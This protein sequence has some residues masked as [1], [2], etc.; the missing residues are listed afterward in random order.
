MADGV[1]TGWHHLLEQEDSKGP[2]VKGVMV[3]GQVIR[4]QVGK[5]GQFMPQLSQIR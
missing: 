3:D 4:N 2:E 1:K 5:E